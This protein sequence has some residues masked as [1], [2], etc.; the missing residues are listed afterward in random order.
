[1]QIATVQNKKISS[2][3]IKTIG[4]IAG[5][6]VLIAASIGIFFMVQ[7]TS[8]Q[9][10]E[11]VPQNVSI[12]TRD[13]TS[14][15]VSWETGKE[16]IAVVEY[17]TAADANT[18]NE[19]AF[20]EIETT[21]HNVNLTSLE[22]NT[23]YFFQI[24]IGDEIYDNGGSFWT[25]TTPPGGDL[26]GSPTLSPDD[27]IISAPVS[28]TPSATISATIVPTPSISASISATLSPTLTGSPTPTATISATLSPT[29]STSSSVCTSNNCTTILQSL[30][31][32]CT[33]QDYVRCLL[34][35][36]VTI[37]Q[38]ATN[39]P[40][41]TP[42][43]SSVKSACAIN[44]FQANSCTSWIWDDMTAKE[45]T[46]SDVFTQYFV[47][48]QST[49]FESS[50]P[51]IWYCNKTVTSN[52]LTLP[53]DTAPTPPPGQAIFCR[54]RAE[55]AIGGVANATDWIYTNSS[56]S[57]FSSVSAVTNCKI[58]YL[59]QNVCGSWNWSLN[60]PNDPL[61]TDA[62][63]HYFLQC[64]NN[65]LFSA[66]ASLTPTPYWYCN[67]TTTDRF[68]D[69]P[70]DNSN[71]PGDGD[72]ITCRVRPEDAQ[73]TDSHAGD[74]VTTSVVCPTSTPTPTTAL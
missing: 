15:T 38:G 58:N 14:A 19:F 23:T 25:I 9:A 26:E 74:W 46:C 5:V 34:G 16:T 52:Q 51:S 48:C 59:Q 22:P 40:T 17:G 39:T 49:S 43:S 41:P 56:C 50:D 32:V 7:G 28:I 6:G 21:T 62:L 11:D 35:A 3:Q 1:M 30:G 70:C 55:S 71:A 68:L 36:N 64:T 44:S 42:L 37:T 69:M 27:P 54:V 60:N 12:Q 10:S 67:N 65:G 33:T 24:R 73:G 72:P 29:P 57:T 47:Q 61:C 53:C 2:Q 8:T 31:A 63:D 18:F 45:K 66:P 20:S 13:A 4:F